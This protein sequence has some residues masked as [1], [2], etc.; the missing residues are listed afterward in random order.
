[1]SPH[2]D[3]LDQPDRLSRFLTGSILFHV[4]LAGGLL[5]YGLLGGGKAVQWGSP[6][7]GGIGDAVAVTP[8]SKIP[9]PRRDAPENPVANDTE[10][11]VPAPPRTSKPPARQQVKDD[12][13]AI[14]LKGRA[15]E[16]AA[17]EAAARNTYRELQRERQNQ[18]YSPT[19]QALSSPMYGIQ[20]AGGVTLGDNTPFG[21]EF[22]WYAKLLKDKV[23][24]KWRTSDLDQRNQNAAVVTFTLRRDGGIGGVRLVQ[25]SGNSALDYSA[26]RALFDA[27]P[28]PPLPQQFT[29]NSV[30]IEMRFS[31]K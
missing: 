28:F 6:K 17:E 20:G 21:S 31:L 14:R 9:L 2:V 26:Q 23:T 22:G 12:R 27:A 15:A 7:G 5:S 11:Q 8:V 13:D 29:R 30:T 19:G 10:S 3:I 16:R 25:P 24:E 18:L 4:V 1:M